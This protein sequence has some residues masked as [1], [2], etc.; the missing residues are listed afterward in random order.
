MSDSLEDL[1]AADVAE[2]GEHFFLSEN[3]LE[4]I[5]VL[6]EDLAR[7]VEHH[8]HQAGFADLLLLLHFA[9]VADHGGTPL[10]T[11]AA[12]TDAA[13]AELESHFHFEP[14]SIADLAEIGGIEERRRR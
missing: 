13:F 8:E 10:L 2:A 5:Q 6:I 14:E 3:A 1:D 9:K 4:E 11:V 7:F 12:V